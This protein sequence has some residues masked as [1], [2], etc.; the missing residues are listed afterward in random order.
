[1]KIRFSEPCKG[2]YVNE[3]I[4]S[5]QKILVHIPSTADSGDHFEVIV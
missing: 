4:F 2:L 1:M 5:P 3:W